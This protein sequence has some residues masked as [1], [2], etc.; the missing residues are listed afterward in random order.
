LLFVIRGPRCLVHNFD[1]ENMATRHVTRAG[2]KLLRSF[3]VVDIE[4]QPDCI[5]DACGSL[6]FSETKVTSKCISSETVSLHCKK[7][8]LKVFPVFCSQAEEA[9]ALSG[10]FFF[11]RLITSC[12]KHAIFKDYMKLVLT[13]FTQ[14]K[15]LQETNW[16][17]QYRSLQQF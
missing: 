17:A 5:V 1:A 16:I 3:R 7:Q 15:L 10:S 11:L 12:Y 13:Y 8:L 6:A 4:L 9:L 14:N 2:P